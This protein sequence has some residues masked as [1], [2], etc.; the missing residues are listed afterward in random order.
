MVTC[1]RRADIL[2]LLCV[3]LSC[4]FVAFLYGV[5]GQVWYLIESIPDVCHLPYFY[6]LKLQANLHRR[7]DEKME[8]A[9]SVSFD[10]KFTRP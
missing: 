8:N 2:A 3:M 9:R 5:Q 7:F 10:I 4:V 6:V 1:W